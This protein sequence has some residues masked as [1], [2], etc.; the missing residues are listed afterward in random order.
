[1]CSPSE[2]LEVIERR[3]KVVTGL[4]GDLS[5]FPSKK[6]DGLSFRTDKDKSRDYAEVFT[7]PHIADAMIGTIPEGG[8]TQ[9]KRVMDLCAGHGQFAVRVLRD[10]HNKHGDDFRLTQFL[11]RKLYFVELQ[12]SSCHKLLWTFSA[13]IN[14]AIGDAL[15]L[16]KLPQKWRGIWVYL[17]ALDEWVDVTSFVKKL[18]KKIS[19]RSSKYRQEEEDEFVQTFE[20]FRDRL[21][22]SVKEYRVEIKHIL[23]T[24]EGRRMFLEYASKAADGIEQNWQS[25]G[26]PEWVVKEMVKAVPEV[27]SLKRI[28]VLFNIEFLEYLI[29][30]AGVKPSKIEFG[31]DSEL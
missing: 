6:S 31:Y 1:M 25:V 26:T 22:Q 24:K 18:R 15:Q 5:V 10:L 12:T 11:N 13:N 30:G 17:E 16:G 28:L 8:L 20:A 7:P 14:L 3:F 21:S 2:K 23:S 4:V 19:N 9:G 29:N 27:K